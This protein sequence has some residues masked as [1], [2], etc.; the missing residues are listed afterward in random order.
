MVMEKNITILLDRRV[1][2]GMK[3]LKDSIS[4][5]YLFISV[6]SMQSIQQ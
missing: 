3:S 6:I 4:M 5:Y 2:E 1:D